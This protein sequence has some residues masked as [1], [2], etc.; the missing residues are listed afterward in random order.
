M[1]VRVNKMFWKS[2]ASFFSNKS[3]KSNNWQKNIKLLLP[4]KNVSFNSYL[5]G[6]VKELK[7][8]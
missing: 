5:N 2:I 3:H 1:L 8:L 7:F 4:M 6:V